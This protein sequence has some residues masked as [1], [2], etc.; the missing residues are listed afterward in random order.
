MSDVY[1]L[2]VEVPRIDHKK[3][4]LFRYEKLLQKLITRDMVDGKLTAIKFHLGGDYNFTHVHAAFVTRI[5]N[6]V[7]ECG[8]TPFITD[9]R[10]DNRL[11]GMIPEAFGCPIYHATG[12][13]DRYA[14]TVKTRSKLLPEVHVAGYLQDADVLIN[15]SHAKGHGM[16][17]FGGAIKNLG[18]GAVTGKTRGAIHH[19]LDRVLQM[20]Q[21]QVHPLQ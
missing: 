4:L 21:G 6:R 7:K 8:G 18:M 19:L 14:Y 5:V 9:H 15:L 11:A 13:R 17:G 3:S 12:L 1:F 10:R 16:C 20:A 2:P